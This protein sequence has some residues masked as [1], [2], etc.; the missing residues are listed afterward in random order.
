MKKAH[1]Y[2]ASFGMSEAIMF[3]SEAAAFRFGAYLI[4]EHDL[5]YLNMLR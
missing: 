4:A 5:T 1:F 2:G 3:W